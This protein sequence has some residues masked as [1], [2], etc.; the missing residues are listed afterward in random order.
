M[1]VKKRKTIFEKKPNFALCGRCASTQV[2]KE[3]SLAFSVIFGSYI[4][5]SYKF[6]SRPVFSFL[7]QKNTMERDFGLSHQDLPTPIYPN[8][9]ELQS[10]RFIMQLCQY[11]FT[12]LFSSVYLL[13]YFFFCS[14]PKV[15]YNDAHSERMERNILLKLCLAEKKLL[16]DSRVNRNF[17]PFGSL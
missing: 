3:E 11:L 16:P 7:C 6:S 10:A 8:K 17:F 15:L 1:L 2:R 9:R 13:L 5:I 14:L 12:S 4:D